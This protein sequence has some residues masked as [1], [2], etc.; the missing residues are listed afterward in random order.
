M[1]TCPTARISRFFLPQTLHPGKSESR[2]I[3]CSMAST[4][5]S[6][7]TNL[8]WIQPKRRRDKKRKNHQH[9]VT[10]ENAENP[11]LIWTAIIGYYESNSIQSQSIVYQEF[12]ALTYKN[13]VGTF[14]DKLDAR[15]S[16]LAAVGL[17]V[18]N[19]E[20][21]DIKESLLAEYI[22]AKISTDF[23]S[24]KEILYQKCPLKALDGKHQE[25]GAPYSAP[26]EIKQESSMKAQG[27]FS[28]SS[29]SK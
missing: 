1:T 10:T 2:A 28:K 9:F 17:V 11:Y 5:F 20:K 24:I 7:P 29:S 23:A 19:P 14:L 16:S 4:S 8:P 6:L 13:S 12:L 27:T 25:T 21:A 18:G 26:P 3:A 22:L 15:L